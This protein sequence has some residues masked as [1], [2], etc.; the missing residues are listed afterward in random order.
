MQYCSLQHPT[1]LLPPDTPTTESFPLWSSCFVLS[2]AVSNCPPLFPCSIL[3]TF[4][5]CGGW[6]EGAG[7]LVFPCLIFCIFILLIGFL[8]QEYWS[9]P[10]SSSSGAHF[11]RTFHSGLFWMALHGMAH[12]F[13]ELTKPP[14]NKAVIH[15]ADVNLSKFWEIV[16]NRGAWPATVPGLQRVRHD[17]VTEQQQ[18]SWH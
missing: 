2:G 16:E 5:P 8:P 14:H 3:N 18:Q 15:E 1:L 9:I 6:G 17:L 10:I 13:T 11:V 4:W 7:M 12:S